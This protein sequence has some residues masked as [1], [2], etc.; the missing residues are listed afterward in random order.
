MNYIFLDTKENFKEVFEI[1]S[2]LIA[3]GSPHSFFQSCPWI[4]NWLKSLHKE[5]ISLKLVTIYNNDQ[6]VVTFFIGQNKFRRRWLFTGSSVSLNTV[7]SE[8]YDALCVEFN[9]FLIR[10]GFNIDLQQ[11]M[12]SLKNIFPWD[13]FKFP[14]VTE[15]LYFKIKSSIQLENDFN[16]L[17][18]HIKPSYYV[19]LDKIR[20]HDNDY[21]SFLSKNRKKQLKST[22]SA[23]SKLGDLDI[24]MADTTSNAL[25]FLN[26]L[27]ELHQKNWLAKGEVG[28]FSNTYLLSFHKLL[29]EDWYD[30]GYIQLL[31]VSCGSCTVGYLYNFVYDKKVYYY[32]SGFEY[33]KENKYRPGFMSHYLAIML[34][35]NI[36][37]RQ[38]D[39]LAGEVAYKKTLSTDSTNL[40]C[41]TLQQQSSRFWFENKLVEMKKKLKY[42][43]NDSKHLISIK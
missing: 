27:V 36:G 29:I 14:R 20:D 40:Y 35:L 16:L 41:L 6:A 42:L 8:Y 5:N 11:V 18:H 19:D 2:S 22:I 43:K 32:Q 24:T 23:Y 38:Y 17:T 34:N 39:F 37:Y 21:F 7:S 13:E 4:E 9:S 30:S 15:D 3:S 10:P 12:N 31:K 25:V 28:A 33:L 1:W 26:D